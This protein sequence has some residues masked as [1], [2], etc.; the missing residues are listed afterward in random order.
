GLVLAVRRFGWA[1]MAVPLA[2]VGAGALTFVGTGIAGLSIIQRYLTVPAVALCVLAGYA[3]LGFTTMSPGPWRS[4]WRAA[5]WGG[6]AVGAAFL[7]LKASSF[8]RL[9]SELRFIGTTHSDLRTLLHSPEVRRGMR[10]GPLTFPTYRLVPDA[11]WMLDAGPSRVRSRAENRRRGAVAVYVST[12]GKYKRFAQAD[13]VSRATNRPPGRTPTL[14]S[15]PFTVYVAR[16][17]RK[18]GG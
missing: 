17:C 6:V 18:R 11:R 14:R 5:A 3:L 4:R 12:E 15:G 16:A 13:G 9:G 2:L 8:G 10:C 7:A 1:R